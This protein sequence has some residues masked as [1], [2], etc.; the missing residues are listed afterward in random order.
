M[1]LHLQPDWQNTLG[2]HVQIWRDGKM[3]RKGTVDAV[4]PDDSLLW[5]SAEGTSS[6]QMVSRHDG[7]QVF[8]H[9]VHRTHPRGTTEKFCGITRLKGAQTL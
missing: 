6:R 7:Y 1:D 4:T 9:S 3:V 8:T 2:P 5:I